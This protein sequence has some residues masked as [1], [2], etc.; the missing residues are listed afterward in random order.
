MR[1][2]KDRNIGGVHTTHFDAVNPIPEFWARK[3]YTTIANWNVNGSAEISGC[4]AVSATVT[5]TEV[6]LYGWMGNE[7]FR[8]SRIK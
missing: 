1:Y 6:I 8:K 7:I 2:R 3:A 4:K 5:P